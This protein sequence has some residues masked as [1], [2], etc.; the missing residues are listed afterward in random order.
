MGAFQLA[1]PLFRGRI[2]LAIGPGNNGSDGIELA[3]ILHEEGYDASVLYYTENGNAENMRRREALDP[4]IPIVSSLAGFDT[5]VEA[6]FGFGIDPG[7]GEF[8]TLLSTIDSR[9]EV[10]ALD[11]PAGFAF[12]A[13]ATVTFMAPKAEMYLPG[14]RGRCGRILRFNPGF[15]EEG[16]DGSSIHL[17]SD[18]DSAIRRISLADYKNSRGHVLAIGGS[19]RFPG[20]LRLLCR[21]A[22]AAAAGLV[23]VLTE[24]ERIFAEHPSL[25]P[26]SDDS[27]SRFSSIAIGPG[28]DAGNEAVFDRAVASGKPMVIDA[29]AL[30]FVHGRRFSHKAVL[31]PHVGE[32]RALMASL[33]IADGLEDASMLAGSLQ[34]ASSLL[35]AVL[36]LKASSIWIADGK[37]IFIYD[38][39]NPSLGTAGSGD[40]LSGIIAALLAQ[41]EDPLRAAV[42][43]VILHQRAGRAAHEEYGYYTA[44]ELIIEAGRLR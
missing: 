42:D 39:A 20:A 44:E 7:R 16:L 37:D 31:T 24:D 9:A 26:F 1:G 36:V 4:A 19:R 43:G 5:V 25:M 17:L 29:D 18:D 8:R 27:F 11:V 22:T 6:L 3:S 30:K 13:D 34:K 12:D 28:W 41:G 10:I 15:P 35:E 40:V 14:L 21:A 33:G 38:G 2:V 32:Y 23:T